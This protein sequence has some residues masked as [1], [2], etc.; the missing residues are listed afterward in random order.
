MKEIK[1]KF[2]KNCFQGPKY[3][4]NA[5]KIYLNIKKK[6]AIRKKLF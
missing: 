5:M 3:T 6:E 2:L 1:E 4:T